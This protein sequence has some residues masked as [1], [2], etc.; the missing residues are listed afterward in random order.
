MSIYPISACRGPDL[1]DYRQR[2]VLTQE[3]FQAELQ[4]RLPVWRGETWKDINDL[5]LEIY[6]IR[7]NSLTKA[8]KLEIHAKTDRIYQRTVGS[9]AC[10]V[11]YWGMPKLAS[12]KKIRSAIEYTPGY[13]LYFQKKEELMKN[14]KIRVSNFRDYT[15]DDIAKTRD[16]KRILS[17]TMGSILMLTSIYY[18]PA[19]AGLKALSSLL[20]AGGMLSIPFEKALFLWNM[21]N[22]KGNYILKDTLMESGRQFEALHKQKL[23]IQKEIDFQEQNKIYFN[24]LKQSFFVAQE[25]DLSITYLRQ[26]QA[27]LIRRQKVLKDLLA[28]RR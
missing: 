18:F 26:E 19:V 24:A 25:D 23:R 7:T 27:E 15:D 6:D 17:V 21:L 9:E 16:C 22:L 11:P 2:P 28:E 3:Q 10:P 20:I 1:N 4:E 13:E 8:Y 5:N 12:L 14:I